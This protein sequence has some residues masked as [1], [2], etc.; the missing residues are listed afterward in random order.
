MIT[1]KHLMFYVDEE[2]TEPIEQFKFS[3]LDLGVT[4]KQTLY[5]RNESYGDIEDLTIILS[6]PTKQGVEARLLSPKSY[7]RLKYHEV[8]P[9]TIETTVLAEAKAGQY[10]PRIKFKFW[11]TQE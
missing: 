2:C 1:N 8:I 4:Q 7:K 9:L 10:K 11:L 6:P 3:R 5:L